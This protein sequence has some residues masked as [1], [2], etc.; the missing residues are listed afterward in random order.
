MVESGLVN[1]FKVSLA[2]SGAERAALPQRCSSAPE[3]LPRPHPAQTSSR[4]WGHPQLLQKLAL[5]AVFPPASVPSLPRFLSRFF[6]NFFSRLIR[7]LPQVSLRF[8]CR[9]ATGSLPQVCCRF[10]LLY[11]RPQL[12][13]NLYWLPIHCHILHI[14]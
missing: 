5:S 14:S 4:F 8:L 11:S 3:H 12:A 1:I 2:P 9:F 10:S 6:R 13:Q 7:T